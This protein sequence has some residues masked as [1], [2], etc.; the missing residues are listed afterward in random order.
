MV[1]SSP[2]RLADALRLQGHEHVAL[3]GAGGKTRTLF[4]LARELAPA[5]VVTTTHLAREEA[6]QADL[7]WVWDPHL[8]AV[9]ARQALDRWSRQGVLLVTGPA[10]AARWTATPALAAVQAWARARGLPVL[11]EADGAARRDL[12]APASHEPAWPPY[13]DGVLVL[14]HAAAVGQP[15]TA[16][17]VHRAERFAALA[18][19]PLAARLTVDAIARVLRHPQGPTR[20]VPRGAW[21]RAVLRGED[22]LTQA[23][24]GRLA[25]ALLASR[26][27]YTAAAVVHTTPRGQV[28]PV[29][30]E[31]PRAGAVL[32]AGA[33][34]RFGGRPKVLLRW[35]GEPLV[36]RAARVAWEAGLRPVVVV[37]GASADA[38]TAAVA[39]LPVRV[40]HNPAWRAG[41]STSVRAALQAIVDAAPATGAVVFFPA[42]HPHL[43]LRLPRALVEAHAATLAPIVAPLL[44]GQRR[45]QPVLFDQRTFTDLA[46]L[47][48]DVGGRALWRRYP[49]HGVLWLDEAVGEDIDTPQDWVRWQERPR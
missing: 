49:A 40:V 18:G 12:K 14:A 27:P 36:R 8:S 1:P 21:V 43:P 2:L 38:V 22:A 20:G 48:G 32:A 9:A 47:Q 31:E 25:R 35:Q 6:A 24:A 30:V 42:D 16:E 34:R 28:R 11:I 15:L 45:G 41:L 23:R 46:T 4:T 29:A 5:L 17:R 33:A 13:A 19:L 7:H 10:H 39:D 37:V 44:M 26:G 3:V